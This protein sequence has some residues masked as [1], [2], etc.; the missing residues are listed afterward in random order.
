LMQENEDG[1]IMIHVKYTK[2]KVRNPHHLSCCC[3]EMMIMALQ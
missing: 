3:E 2:K 1:N